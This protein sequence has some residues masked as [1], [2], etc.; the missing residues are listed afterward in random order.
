MNHRDGGT[1]IVDPHSTQKYHLPKGCPHPYYIELNYTSD[2]LAW[3]LAT[4]STRGPTVRPGHLACGDAGRPTVST[5]PS[6]D[7]GQ[8]CAQSYCLHQN[9]WLESTR[10]PSRSVSAS[11]NLRVVETGQTFFDPVTRAVYSSF[12]HMIN[13]FGC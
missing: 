5:V 7:A 4:G 6:H 3:V 11:G 13:R 1:A 9:Q 10:P 12:C 2:D 8:P